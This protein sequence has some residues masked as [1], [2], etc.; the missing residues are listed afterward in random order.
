MMIKLA[1]QQFLAQW[2]AG[3]VRVLLL[4]L[5][6]AV[7][8]ITGVTFFTSRIAAHLNTQGGLV[9]GGDMVLIADH[10][11][12]ENAIRDAKMQGLRYTTTVEFPS[13][14][15]AG[16]KNQLAEIKAL[17]TGFPLRGDMTVQFSVDAEAQVVKTIPNPGE[18]WI[19][20]RLAN[21]LSIGLG[22]LV[23]LGSTQLRVSGII[24]REPSRGGDMF[25]F[26]PRLMMNAVD[27]AKT[28]LIQY[29]SRVKYQLL[30]AGDAKA[31]NTFGEQLKGNLQRGE[32]LQDLK[33]ARPEIKSALEK[34]ETFLGLAAMV[35]ILLSIAAMLLAS[36]PYI[37]R[38]I[39]TAALLR[40]FGASKNQIQQILL[41]QCFF[42]ALVGAT[43][44]CLFGYILQS[45]LGSI[46]GT[47]FLETLPQ[48]DF[49]L[50]FIGY[51]VSFLV[52][53]ALMLPNINAIKNS[54]V[55]NILRTDVE[56]KVTSAAFRFI[57]VLIVIAL[58]I[59][60]LAKSIQLAITVILGML[61]VCLLSAGL[62]Y[63][64]ANI[65]YQLTQR[66]QYSKSGLFNLL[67][68]GLANL[69]R[70]KIL[71]LVQVVG[72]SI[73][74]MVIILLM[75]VK[76]DLLNA[77]QDALPP[78]AP[79]HFAI[80]IQPSQVESIEGF[81]KK[82][83]IQKPQIFPMVRGR[84]V[85]KNGQA[86]S[87]DMYEDGRAKRLVSREFNLSMA[88]EM[89]S[90]NHLLAGEWWQEK[91]NE[92]PLISIEQDIANALDIKV[93]DV[94][95]YDIAGRKINLNVTSIRKVEWDSMRAN[96]FAVTPP[97]T[98]ADYPKSYMT[99]F[100]LK[101]RQSTQ[102]DQLVKE[103]PNL[104][105]INVA[106]LMEQIRGIMQKMSLAVANVFVLCIV[107]G[108]V[109]LYAALI[110]TRDARAKEAS[111]FRIFGASRKQVSVV[112]IAE[113]LGIAFIAASV[114][115]LAANFIA[116]YVS[117]QMF[118]I[119]YNINGLLSLFA[120]ITALILIPGVAWFV[121]RD[122]LN[123]PPKQVLNSI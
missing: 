2:R 108:L 1:W 54:P 45:V 53:F 117:K 41:W 57:P 58:I 93:G 62:A 60:V 74:A 42:I 85:E 47:L 22:D 7:T 32:R 25:S 6:V 106:S 103:L 81:L 68:I 48:P 112:M 16:E 4:A 59:F 119:P 98:L 109:V 63:L 64:F 97:D 69:K 66:S 79:N 55:V 83:D 73:G 65:I 88:A 56:A 5:I 71:T 19:E 13:M 77:W 78:D 104:T 90:D 12:P 23:E 116:Y 95:T 110:A 61:A 27:V 89:Q 39:E 30:V 101:D 17:N 122:Y 24:T 118:E 72:F 8:A 113:Y 46:A 26:A 10:A 70:N 100:Y 80:N 99:A 92:K 111:L 20:P 115:L 67:K 51:A 34:A 38:N 102:L 105:I 11:I 37:S 84:L 40:C 29:G 114:A 31:I 14:A 18:A 120:Y 91:D 36:G 75:I 94:L 87:A 76:N 82:I 121:M 15:I 49:S 52:L 21:L 35:S 86:L 33:T 3:D 28:E 9:L 44:G 123:Q 50:I 96:F 43:I 107:A